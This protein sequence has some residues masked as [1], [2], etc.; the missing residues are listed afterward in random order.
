MANRETDDVIKQLDAWDATHGSSKESSKSLQSSAQSIQKF[1]QSQRSL[2]DIEKQQPTEEDDEDEDEDDDDE[3][4]GR[5]PANVAVDVNGIEIGKVKA[6][7]DSSDESED[8]GRIT[9]IINERMPDYT[10]HAIHKIR[11]S[12]GTTSYTLIDPGPKYDASG[13]VVEPH[14]TVLLHG[15]TDS[16]YIW[17]DIV[18]VLSCEEIIG[19]VP[20][21][22][23][24]DFYGRGRS[25]WSGF[26]CTL[27]VFVTQL[28][29]LLD[30]LNLS[31]KPVDLV[32]YCLGGAVATG[33][34]VKFPHLCRSL[35]LINTAGVRLK[36]PTRYN[37]LK[38][39]CIGE[40][41]MLRSRARMA[42]NQLDYYYNTSY[43]APH[44]SL[45]E[46]QM[47]M[48]TWQ[49]NNTPGY[50]GSILSTFRYFPL[51]GMGDLFAVAG[52]RNRPVLVIWGNDDNLF[53]LRKALGTIENA[54]PEAE[55]I[56][57]KECGHN[58]IFEKFDDVATALVDF[59]KLNKIAFEK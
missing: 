11:L 16:C 52:R 8:K 9:G 18:E 42:E 54:F 20:R 6:D 15:L 40:I 44:R 50:V 10:F 33:F 22:L 55:I 21:I 30:A 36:N 29:E 2:R 31:R 43:N 39:K 25:P 27:D 35:A 38:K 59:Y 28:K 48:V 53:P 56:A 7:D 41:V 58:P 12:R 26:P 57:I 46:K 37:I 47:L 34:S 19:A 13:D 14:T 5:L 1:K 3:E 23:V 49:L 24:F 45:I 51:S 17:E 32:G 4:E